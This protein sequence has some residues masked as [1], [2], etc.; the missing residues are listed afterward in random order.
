MK[1]YIAVFQDDYDAMYDIYD[2]DSLPSNLNITGDVVYIFRTDQPL[3]NCKMT[4]KNFLKMLANTNDF[5]LIEMGA[6][7]IISD[8]ID[9]ICKY[10]INEQLMSI[11][12]SKCYVGSGNTPDICDRKIIIEEVESV[13]QKIKNNKKLTIKFVG[14]AAKYVPDEVIDKTLS[15][16]DNLEDIGTI[17]DSIP[18][19]KREGKVLYKIKDLYNK[20]KISSLAFLCEKYYKMSGVKSMVLEICNTL[21]GTDLLEFIR[22][23]QDKIPNLVELFSI[24]RLGD[25]IVAAGIVINKGLI[26]DNLYVDIYR[27]TTDIKLKAKIA[28]NWSNIRWE[29]IEKDLD[30]ILPESAPNVAMSILRKYIKNKPPVHPIINFLNRLPVKQKIRAINEFYGE[31][32]ELDEVIEK[33]MG[34]DL[35]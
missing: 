28:S 19:S 1:T 2:I 30:L 27:Q 25:A 31:Y 32:D 21:R 8:I 3:S 22:I 6:D 23:L 9:I 35:K 14:L 33:N 26:P 7:Y 4:E 18:L 29:E 11:I 20:N 15:E 10:D 13:L 17:V 12:L 24:D 5:D 16:T 34:G